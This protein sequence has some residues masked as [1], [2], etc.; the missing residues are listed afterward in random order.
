[1]GQ[2]QQREDRKKNTQQLM[3]QPCK[4]YKTPVEDQGEI[5]VQQ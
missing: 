1:M 3:N 4:R 2:M 5:T